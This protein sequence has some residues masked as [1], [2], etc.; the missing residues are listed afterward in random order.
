M[1]LGTIIDFAHRFGWKEGFTTDFHVEPSPIIPPKVSGASI[2]TV[3]RFAAGFGLVGLS[4][5]HG[6]W[7]SIAMANDGKSMPMRL[8]FPR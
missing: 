7:F 5:V 8:W 4:A 3:G 1:G 2:H 6:A